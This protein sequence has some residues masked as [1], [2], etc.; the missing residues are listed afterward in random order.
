MGRNNAIAAPATTPVN[1]KSPASVTPM[2]LRPIRL[3]QVSSVMAVSSTPAR[4][5]QNFASAPSD[6]IEF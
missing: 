2:V 4:M 1:S 3:A 6:F 5:A